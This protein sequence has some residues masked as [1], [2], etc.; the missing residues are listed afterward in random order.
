MQQ[1][2]DIPDSATLE[3]IVREVLAALA[4]DTVASGAAAEDR[5]PASA[6]AEPNPADAVPAAAAPRARIVSTRDGELAV[7]ERVV[8]V[9]ALDGRLEGIRRL[10]LQPGA[11]LTPAVRDLLRQRRIVVTYGPVPKSVGVAGAAG[12]ETIPESAA[13]AL[14]IVLVTRRISAAQLS[15]LFRG[16]DLKIMPEEMDCVVRASQRAAEAVRRPGG[17]AVVVTSLIAA[18]VCLA[19]RLSGV[20]AVAARR[21]NEVALDAAAVG[22]NVLVA[23][24]RQGVFQVKRMIVEFARAPRQ[25]P[26][27]LAPHLS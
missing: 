1:F 21:P 19:N 17:R 4:A 11:I 6:A 5:A 13:D 24:A 23:D 27:A 3:R 15:G 18:G 20:R 10:L 26:E 8:T 14:P 12:A 9:A 7:P 2:Q 16:E 22:A 25:C